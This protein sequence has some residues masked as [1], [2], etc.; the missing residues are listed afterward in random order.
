MKISSAAFKHNQ[1]IPAKHTCDGENISPP[2]S[3]EQVPSGCTTLA[4]I[5]DDP[6]APAGAWLHW[7]VWNIDP[8]TASIPE[9]AVPFGASQGTTDFH[10]RSYGGPC[11]PSGT[12]RYY[13]KLYALDTRLDLSSNTN[14]SALERAMQGHVLAEAEL[15][16]LYR[17]AGKT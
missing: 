2:L 9:R 13:F 7:I 1:S 11:P 17:R 4:L 3:L 8:R 16:G 14:Q 5:V 12:H 10:D 15:I 6:D